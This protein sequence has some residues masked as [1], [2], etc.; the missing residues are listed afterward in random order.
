MYVHNIRHMHQLVKV[1]FQRGDAGDTVR[2]LRGAHV[3][4][5]AAAVPRQIMQE[6][7]TDRNGKPYI[8]RTLLHVA[9]IR[10]D[11]KHK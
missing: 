10:I 8:F 4:S 9:Y 7:D 1:V 2:C 6:V 3:A 5:R 11:T